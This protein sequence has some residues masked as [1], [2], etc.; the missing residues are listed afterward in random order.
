MYLTDPDTTRAVTELS[1]I[2]E[3]VFDAK[4]N[5][6]AYTMAFVSKMDEFYNEINSKSFDFITDT[7]K[8]SY[9]FLAKLI[10]W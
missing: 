8:D 1:S 3:A 10:D 4:K 7:N 2:N 5:M 9:A 6:I